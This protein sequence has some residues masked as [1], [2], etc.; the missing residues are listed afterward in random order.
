MQQKHV[1]EHLIN[2]A[3][4]SVSTRAV[5]CSPGRD[6]PRSVSTGGVICLPRLN[7]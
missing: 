3:P 1:N 7:E 2:A 4:L 5:F 6:G